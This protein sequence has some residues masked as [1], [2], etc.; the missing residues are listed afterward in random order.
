MS[1]IITV[2]T[3]YPLH[4]FVTIIIMILLSVLVFKILKQKFKKG[5]ITK[6][7]WI[8]WWMLISYSEV[9]LYCTVFGRRAWEYYRYNFDLGYS[10]KDII[11]SADYT[12]IGQILI[13]ILMFVPIGVLCG[14]AIDRNKLRK[15]CF[16]GVLI[17]FVIEFLQLILRRG[18]CEFDDL[19]SNFIGTAV[20]Y[21]LL[22]CFEKLIKYEK[23]NRIDYNK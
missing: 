6:E 21:F 11:F 19:I 23:R 22:K 7:K 15:S 12:L 10:Y 3:Y 1:P 4:A 20:G 8:A 9:L 16:Y 17:S 13:N 14:V 5:L 18:Y 2:F